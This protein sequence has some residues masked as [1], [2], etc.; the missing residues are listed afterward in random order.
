MKRR[1]KRSAAFFMMMAL[2]VTLLQGVVGQPKKAFASSWPTIT[3]AKYMKCYTI[4]TGNNTM[5]YTSSNLKTKLGTIYASDELYVYSIN[6]SWAYLS[7][8]T[9]KARKYGYVPTRVLTSNNQGHVLGT[10]TAKISTLKRAGSISYGYISKGDSVMRVATSGSYSQVIYPV[11]TTWKMGWI[12]TADYNAYISNTSSS[13]SSAVTYSGSSAAGKLSEYSSNAVHCYTLA[14]SGKVYAYR[15]VAL[16]NK[17]TQSYIAC[18]SDEVY[19]QS[20]NLTYGSVKLSYPISSGRKSMYF[21]VADIM[22]SPA[23][24]P[25]NYYADHRINTYRWAGSTQ[26]GYIENETV[27]VVG[28]SGNYTQIIYS[29]GSKQY[30]MAFIR[31]S[32]MSA[33]STS[34]TATAGNGLVQQNIYNLA[35]ASVGT[36]GKTYQTWCGISTSDPYCVAYATYIANQAMINSGYT[37]AQALQ[38]VPKKASTALL[39][40][41]FRNRG[42]YYSYA[43]WYNSNRGVSM[44]KNTTLSSYVPKVGDLAIIDNNGK[45]STGPEHTGIVIAVNG[46]SMTLAEGNTGTGTN[47]TRTVK[48]H[49]Y[50]MGATYWYRIDDSTA[51]IVGLCNPAY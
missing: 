23:S 32:D 47:A 5:V 25:Y 13:G 7:Y 27:V 16:K 11:G 46:S 6:D 28:T 19:V 31:T 30:K 18:S 8:P 44:S 35:M 9:S 1:W 26:Y 4:S 48:T 3:A 12:R 33:G 22:A 36:K 10:S 15:D 29:I 45:I 21:R 38:I 42:R 14:S 50:K 49:T 20:V 51:K 2:L 37:S 39:A 34:S 43:A 41:W 40:D 24:S 17:T